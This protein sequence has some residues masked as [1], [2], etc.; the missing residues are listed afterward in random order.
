MWIELPL[1]CW[2]V[3]VQVQE[4]RLILTQQLGNWL[5]QLNGTWMIIW[6]QV[7]KQHTGPE[8]PD[9]FSEEFSSYCTPKKAN[10]SKP[11]LLPLFWK[12]SKHLPKHFEVYKFKMSVFSGIFFRKILHLCYSSQVGTFPTLSDRPWVKALI[13]MWIW[14]AWVWPTKLPCWRLGF[15]EILVEK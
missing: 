1:F 12:I 11:D 13:L 6:C 10:G 8:L 4:G 15:L 2:G 14:I 9:F 5:V 7:V 3:H